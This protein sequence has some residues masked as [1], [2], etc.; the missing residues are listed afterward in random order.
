MLSD[1]Q[2]LP[3]LKFGDTDLKLELDE[4]SPEMKEVARKELRETPE[5]AKEAMEELKA[6]LKEDTELTVPHDNEQWL[7]RFLR[8]CKFYPQSAY[9]LVS[10][11]FLDRNDSRSLRGKK[12]KK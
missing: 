9:E 2:E 12:K 1:I 3:A 11:K 5:L 6:L 10:G 7:I 8:P 4:L